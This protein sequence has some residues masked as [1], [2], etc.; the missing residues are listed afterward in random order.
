MSLSVAFFSYSAFTQEEIE[1]TVEDASALAELMGAPIKMDVSSSVFPT[2]MGNFYIS[3]E[4]VGLIM[5]MLAP[6]SYE[7]SKVELEGKSTE[8]GEDTKVKDK[9]TFTYNGREFSFVK[10]TAKKDGKKLWLEMYAVGD[11]NDKTIFIVGACDLK[12]KSTFVDHFKK[13]AISS[14]I[15]KSEPAE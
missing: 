10:A 7:S 5:A 6:Q 4:P 2:Q 1:T 3:E 13:A 8:F 11:G 14:E 15:E 12:A 9:G